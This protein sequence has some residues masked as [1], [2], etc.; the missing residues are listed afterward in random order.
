[1]ILT[2]E[3]QAALKKLL[4]AIQSHQE[5]KFN[6]DVPFLFAVLGEN[7]Q[8]YGLIFQWDQNVAESILILE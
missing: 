8:V 5:H 7:P 3:A 1:M 2:K 4:I 6:L